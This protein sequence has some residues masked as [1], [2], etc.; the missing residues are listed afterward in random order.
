MIH[1]PDPAQ[2]STNAPGTWRD[3]APDVAVPRATALAAWQSVATAILKDA[4]SIFGATITY[5]HL[6]DELFDRTGFRTRQLIHK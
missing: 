6:Q 1:V 4:A 5:G 3:S 2:G